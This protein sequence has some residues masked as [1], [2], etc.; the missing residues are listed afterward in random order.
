MVAVMDGD[1]V[2]NLHLVLRTSVSEGV[3]QMYT[4]FQSKKWQQ[5]CSKLTQKFEFRIQKCTN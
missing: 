2:Q 3:R 5:V 1:R 4:Q